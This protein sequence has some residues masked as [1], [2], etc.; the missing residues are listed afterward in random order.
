MAQRKSYLQDIDALVGL[1]RAQLATPP[2]QPTDAEALAAR[3]SAVLIPIFVGA[4]GHPHLLFIE[5]SANLLNH[6]GQIAFPGGKQDPE[7]ASLAATA[8]R[9]AEEEIGLVPERVTLLGTLPPTFTVVSNYLIYPQVSLV[10]GSLAEIAPRINRE[11]VASLIDAPLTT[12]ADPANLGSEEWVLQGVTRLIT[13]YQVGPHRIW[14]ATGYILSNL[15]GLL[16]P[17]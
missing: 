11:E 5:R 16:P 12:L 15:L 9:E 4:D 6:S 10:R 1:L 14:G 7:D 13:F 3:P 17:P 8:L 2:P